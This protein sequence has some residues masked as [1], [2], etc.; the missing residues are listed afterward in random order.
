MTTTV[1]V[2]NDQIENF[3]RDLN[4]ANMGHT[5]TGVEGAFADISGDFVVSEF[6]IWSN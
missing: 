3:I 5:K 1:Y 6:T 4:A 2:K